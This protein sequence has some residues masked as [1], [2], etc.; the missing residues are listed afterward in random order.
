MRHGTYTTFEPNKLLHPISTDQFDFK[1]T[2]HNTALWVKQGN[3]TFK[4]YGDDGKSQG[5]LLEQTNGDRHY[6]DYHDS[7]DQETIDFHNYLKNF[8]GS[9]YLYKNEY[10]MGGMDSIGRLT[11]LEVG[12]KT[13]NKCGLISMVQ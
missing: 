10:R 12:Q 2:P 5:S 7:I 6:H 9:E 1:V 3:S 11:L 13:S 4:Q 8:V